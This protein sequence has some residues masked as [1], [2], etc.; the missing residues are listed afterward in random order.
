MT[1][2]DPVEDVVA[3]EGGDQRIEMGVSK[4]RGGP[5]KWM[6]YKEKT[7][8]KWMIWGETPLFL[9]GHPNMCHPVCI[10][11]LPGPHHIEIKHTRN[12]A[13]CKKPKQVTSNLSKIISQ[14]FVGWLESLRSL[15]KNAFHI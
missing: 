12:E 4:N 5:P 3:F 8:F 15:K 2:Q 7:L 6:V 11:P 10:L 9:E 13:P 1:V 14:S